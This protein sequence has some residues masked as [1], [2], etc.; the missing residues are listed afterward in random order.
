MGLLEGSDSIRDSTTTT[1]GQTTPLAMDRTIATGESGQGVITG[2]GLGQPQDNRSKSEGRS[3]AIR[4]AEQN[5]GS[6]ARGNGEGRQSQGEMMSVQQQQQQQPQPVQRQ[7]TQEEQQGIIIA[8]HQQQLL[9]M[10]QQFRGAESY[11]VALDGQQMNAV[12]ATGQGIG[13]QLPSAFLVG[14]NEHHHQQQRYHHNMGGFGTLNP[15]T[16]IQSEK[17]RQ[18]EGS[19]Q[20]ELCGNINYAS[21]RFCNMNKCH[22]PR[23]LGEWRCV[24]GNINYRNRSVCN[25]RKCGLPRPMDLQSP[26]LLY[27]QRAVESAQL[28]QQQ[29][30][31]FSEH[32][33][34]P[35]VPL[36]Q[37]VEEGVLLAHQQQ[38]TGMWVCSACNNVNYPHRTVCNGHRCKRPRQEVDPVYAQQ[39]G[40]VYGSSG[41]NQSPM[42][43]P[44]A[45]GPFS[46][47]LTG[48]M[49]ARHGVVAG[50]AIPEGSWTC[51]ECGN[52]NYPR[53]PFCNK[54]GCGAARPEG[55]GE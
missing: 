32:N 25:M 53:R 1:T 15:S 29:Q 11:G 46:P 23:P 47:P 33:A 41:N 45:A 12:F 48:S 19:W 17:A 44:S 9:M 5:Y 2:E 3:L 10:Q 8:H 38:M 22:A 54:R 28:Q 50:D 26:A 18:T 4:E 49:D 42:L 43:I 31:G 52:L 35:T 51:L 30:A 14:G 6:D 13:Y 39:L 7:L 21:R 36:P 40:A 20:C 34:V 27:N 24:C 55:H 16:T 37:T